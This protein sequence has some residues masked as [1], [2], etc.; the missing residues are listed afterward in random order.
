MPEET[1]E[2]KAER[3]AAELAAKPPKYLTADEF[4]E[5]L[6]AR[7]TALLGALREITQGMQPQQQQQQER[8]PEK[9]QEVEITGDEF[10][11]NPGAAMKK[12]FDTKVAP[13]LAQSGQPQVDV[14]ARVRLEMMNLQQRVKPEDWAK[15]SQHFQNVIA[16]TDARVLATPGGMDATWRLTKSYADDMKQEDERVE[17][18]K[19][20]RAQLA[21]GAARPANESA[22]VELADDEKAM[23][24]RMGLSPEDYRKYG[25]AEEV[26][27]GRQ[28]K[29]K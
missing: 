4:D 3:E 10:L 26:Q 28:E 20:Q 7:D 11:T 5:R 22:K 9:T 15:Y 18:E 21:D 24:E 23:A 12:F 6:K 27:V 19:K 17:H 13:V 2:Q 14:D 29:K 8:Q 1:P 25:S 16:K